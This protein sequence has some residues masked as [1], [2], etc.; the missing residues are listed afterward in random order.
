MALFPIDVNILPLLKVF[1]DSPATS[2][3]FHL[4][5][6]PASPEDDLE[7]QHLDFVLRTTPLCPLCYS[8]VSFVNPLTV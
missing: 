8:F 6:I 5:R 3:L 1:I 2:G 7:R 4:P